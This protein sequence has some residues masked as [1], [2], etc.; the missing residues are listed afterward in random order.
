[1]AGWFGKKKEVSYGTCSKCGSLLKS[2]D[3]H[4]VNQKKYCGQC[5]QEE[6]PK[7]TEAIDLAALAKL[8]SMLSEENLSNAA[9]EK[10]KKEPVSDEMLLKIFAEYFAPNKTFYSIQGSDEYNAYFH[11]VN[12][13]KL[14]MV[15]ETFLFEAATKRSKDELIDMIN[16]P[17]PAITNMLICGMIFCMGDYAVIPSHILCVDF[18]DR[19]P[20]CIAVFL[21]LKAQKLPAERRSQMLDA[22]DGVDHKPL[23]DA[24]ASLKVCDQSWN[25]TVL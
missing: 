20:Y 1:M 14:E 18:A 23:L 10:E 8:M 24:L 17:K 6:K 4:M 25:C 13:A 3:I 11:A 22:G 7:K 21:L 5:Y 2:N 12:Q 15:K 19:I 16:H 9:K